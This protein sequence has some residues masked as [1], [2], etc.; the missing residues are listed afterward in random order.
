[1]TRGLSP[2][3]ATNFRPTG[4]LSPFLYTGVGGR[5][6]A[7]ACDLR[8]TRQLSPDLSIAFST[9]TTGPRVPGG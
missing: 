9:T 3:A 4:P 1:M 6:A 8:P 5:T 7:E 2:N